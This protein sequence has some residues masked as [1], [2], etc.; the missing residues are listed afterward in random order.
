[1]I[2]PIEKK[3]IIIQCSPKHTGSTLLVNIIYGFI[4]P[5][6]PIPW[7]KNNNKNIHKNI[8]LKTHDCNIDKWMNDYKM[9]NLYFI[10]SER[11]NL[12]IDPKFKKYKNVLCINYNELINDSVE[13][14]ISRLEKKFS[15][16]L[17]SSFKIDKPAAYTPLIFDIK[18]F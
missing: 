3:D 12:I 7:M 2:N 6:D 8:I 14:I 16:F 9:Y 4:R 17:P 10:C 11:D 1:M 13:V 15:S 5:D 18:F